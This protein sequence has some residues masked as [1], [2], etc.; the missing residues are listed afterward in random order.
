MRRSP[1]LLALALA[2][3]ALSIT[4]LRLMQQRHRPSHDPR[5]LTSDTFAQIA[6]RALPQT[7]SIYVA[8]ENPGL[9]AMAA[10]RLAP[11]LLELAPE[12]LHLIEASGSGV[13][14]SEDGLIVT[15][16]HLF[17][18]MASPEIEVHL[19]DGRVFRGDQVVLIASD[20]LTDLA[21]LRVEGRGLT[22]ATFGDSDRLNIGDWVIAI[23]NPLDLANTVTQGIVSAKYR[24]TDQGVLVDFIQSSAHIDPGSSGGALLNI[25]GELVGINT[26]IATQ[27]A[28]WEGFGFALPSNTVREVIEHLAKRGHVPRG[29]IGI[30]FDGRRE[31][32][33]SMERRLAG[34]QGPGGVRVIGVQPG[35]PADLAGVRSGDIIVT[36]AGQPIASGADLLRTVAALPIGSTAEV[37]AWRGDLRTSRGRHVTFEVA[38]AERP[39]DEELD[40]Q[41]A[42]ERAAVRAAAASP[43]AIDLPSAGLALEWRPDRRELV[44]TRVKPD[45]PAA[46]ASFA[47][48]DLVL[49]VNGLP[50]ISPVHL[51]AALRLQPAT[52]RNHVFLVGRGQSALYLTLGGEDLALEPAPEIA[53]SPEAIAVRD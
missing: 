6:Q 45:S 11:Q 42:A 19:Y 2:L 16:H 37:E 20:R 14:V 28:R 43:E 4:N 41:R 25:A 23:G 32:L 12:D 15:N 5:P 8:G 24:R 17:Q 21:L 49:R 44:V 7:V 50:V 39:T 3:V 47:E 33:T 34:Y 30:N 52:I 26:A 31:G 18:G 1:L 13:I 22:P 36:I 10:E 40:A 51:W 38:I 48:G 35:G 29:Y 9:P 53:A 46:R 27:T